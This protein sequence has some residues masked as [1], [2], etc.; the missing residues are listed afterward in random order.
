MNLYKPISSINKEHEIEILTETG[1]KIKFKIIPKVLIDLENEDNGQPFFFV[2]FENIYEGVKSTDTA[3][4]LKEIKS[5]YKNVNILPPETEYDHIQIGFVYAE[6]DPNNHKW[7]INFMDVNN[8]SLFGYTGTEIEL[9]CPFSTMSWE[10]GTWHGRF[11]VNKEH[12]EKIT[13]NEFG[14]F[15]ITG[16]SKNS[17]HEGILTQFPKET[18]KISLRYDIN[19]NMWY[20]DYLNKKNVIGSTPC[21]SIICD[22]PF[23]GNIEFNSSKP[24]VTAEIKIKDLKGYSLALN[25]LILK[26]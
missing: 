8:K 23:K 15:K 9:D 12:V 1:H 3:L 5:K 10:D 2:N 7:M 4:S 21:K 16:S 14:K 26:K 19:Q 6:N 22:V 11:V 20:C 17:I 18:T 24:K 25:A 13:E